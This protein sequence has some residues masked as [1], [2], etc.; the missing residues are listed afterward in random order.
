MCQ[1]ISYSEFKGT[2]FFNFFNLKEVNTI[3]DGNKRNLTGIY[4]KPGGFQEHVDIQLKILHE[5]ILN[6]VLILDREWIGNEKSINPFGKD[7][8]KSFL[9]ALI[10]DALNQEFKILLVQSLWNLKGDEDRIMCI[11]EVIK[12]WEDASPDVKV[13]L[14]VYRNKKDRAVKNFE[15]LTIMMENKKDPFTKKN[16]LYIRL[17]WSN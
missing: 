13:F 8:A 7:I 9:A 16:R 12:N 15:N 10:P 17:N 2:D 4:L 11:D 14:E 6:A 1:K 3:I 5:E